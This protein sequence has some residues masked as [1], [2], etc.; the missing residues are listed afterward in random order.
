[1]RCGRGWVT[2]C[3]LALVAGCGSPLTERWEGAQSRCDSGNG[4]TTV[5]LM[6]D[7]PVTL[8][9]SG[10]WRRNNVGNTWVEF[11]ILDATYI[12]TT[13]T[14]STEA[15]V[16]LFGVVTIIPT[17]YELTRSPGKLQG[18]STTRSSS[19]TVTCE[20]DLKPSH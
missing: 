15:R 6:L 9:P 18:T 2:G 13:L 14:F 17:D 7:G 16:E 11:D 3:L 10:T 5:E 4:S 20:I 1:M 12:G 19:I 8:S